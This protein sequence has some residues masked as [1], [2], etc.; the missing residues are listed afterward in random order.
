MIQELINRYKRM[1]T[2]HYLRQTYQFQYAFVGM[3]QHSLTNLYPVI[4]Y[5]GIPLKYVCVTSERKAQLIERKFT[6]VKTT[7]MIED[8]LNDDSIK[9]VFLSASPSAHFTIASQVLKSGKSLY[10]E[11]PPCQTSGELKQLIELQ[12]LHGVVVAMVGLQKRYAPAIQLLKRRIDKERLISYD[13]RYQTGAY[14]EG[15]ALLELYIHPIDLVC[16]LFG[17]PEIIACRL[18][19][20]SSYILILQHPNIIG[21]LELSTAYSWTS[22]KESLRV[23]THSGIYHLSQMDELTLMPKT[24]SIFGIPLEKVHP[25]PQTIE[26]LYHRKGFS[27]ILTNNEIY[28]QGYFNSIDTFINAVEKRLSYVVTPFSA[29]LPAYDVIEQI[30]TSSFISK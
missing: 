19:T 25:C 22:S 26:Y 10:I 23:N 15:D 8:I 30:R 20:K 21:T 9:G 6:G 18:V 12:Q 2:E 28:S 3:G 14:V 11:K 16:Y 24:G 17:K 13:L 7:I 1:R 29:I 5:L 4:N 27:P